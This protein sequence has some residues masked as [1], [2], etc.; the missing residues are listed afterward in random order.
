MYGQCTQVCREHP[1]WAAAIGNANITATG[2]SSTDGAF[3]STQPLDDLNEQDQW[4]LPQVIFDFLGDDA[5]KRQIHLLECCLYVTKQGECDCCQT[6]G[7]DANNSYWPQWM[8]QL[9]LTQ[10][11]IKWH[12]NMHDRSCQLS[13]WDAGVSRW[14]QLIQHYQ[15]DHTIGGMRV[16][17]DVNGNDS[18]EFMHASQD[19]MVS[20]QLAQSNQWS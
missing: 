11:M 17:S 16:K 14:G 20:L 1:C 2:G 13:G 8:E 10:H 5:D 9:S 12:G 15:T 3:K 19:A 7:N 6:A 18:A 4:S